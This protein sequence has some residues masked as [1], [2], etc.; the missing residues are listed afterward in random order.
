MGLIIM[1][2]SCALLVA[3]VSAIQIEKPVATQKKTKDIACHIGEGANG[4][5]QT[6]CD[7]AK[8]AVDVKPWP[9]TTPAPESDKYWKGNAGDVHANRDGTLKAAPEE[10]KAEPTDP[11]K[12]AA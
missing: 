4:V 5:G 1:F 6:V 11:K 12:D 9:R 3:S 8:E 2:K 7:M 10:P